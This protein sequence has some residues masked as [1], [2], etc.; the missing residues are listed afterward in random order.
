MNTPAYIVTPEKIL[1][2][3]DEMNERVDAPGY[4]LAERDFAELMKLS[5]QYRDYLK[6]LQK[7]A[8]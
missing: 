5:Q 1:E 2:E 6:W 3:L 4:E 8:R 7:A